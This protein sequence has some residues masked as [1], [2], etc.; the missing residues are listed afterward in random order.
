MAAAAAEL[1]EQERVMSADVCP[2]KTPQ[3][4]LMCAQATCYVFLN[5]L[6]LSVVSIW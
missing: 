2:Q 4:R 5:P 1:S 3:K 6:E